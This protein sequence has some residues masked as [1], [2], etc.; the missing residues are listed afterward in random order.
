MPTASDVGKLLGAVDP[1]FRVPLAL[2]AGTGLRRGEVLG[3]EWPAIELDSKT[4]RLTV[5]GTL[6]RAAG[7]LVVLPPKTAR[8]RRSVPLSPSLVTLLRAHRASQ[9]E[10]RLLVGPAWTGE[11]V[12]DRGDGRP[13]DPDAFGKAFRDARD[14]AGLHA[15]RL[16]DLRHAFASMLV[17]AGTN[18]RVVSDVLGHATIGFTLQTYV[19]P[20]EEA[21]VA[22]ATEAERVLGPVIGSA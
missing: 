13:M 9:L 1:V 7:A 3:I 10:R 19:H 5:A 16:H 20:D 17:A 8:S 22:V 21:A 12:F 18:P 11:Y 6:Q 2:S 14:G 15:V 4:P